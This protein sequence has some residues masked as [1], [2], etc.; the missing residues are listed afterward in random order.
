MESQINYGWFYFKRGSR[1]SSSR[2]Y[3]FLEKSLKKSRCGMIKIEINE[4]KYIVFTEIEKL[5]SK[6]IC[7]TCLNLI[8]G[9][10]ETTFNIK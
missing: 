10:G 5:S 1:L 9:V 7:K 8:N 2:Q 4:L 3:H 6:K